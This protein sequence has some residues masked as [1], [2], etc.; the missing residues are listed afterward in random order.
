[1]AMNSKEKDVDWGAIHPWAKQ[2][3]D[4]GMANKSWFAV[5]HESLECKAWAEYFARL[6]WSPM[7]FRRLGQFGTPADAKWTAPCQWP[8]WL[9]IEQ[10]QRRE[11]FA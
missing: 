6:G 7:S 8:E 5:K 1:M 9:T 4:H 2:A 3:Y 11:R 10:P